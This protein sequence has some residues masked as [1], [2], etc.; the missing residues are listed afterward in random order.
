MKNRILYVMVNFL[1]TLAMVSIMPKKVR[2]KRVNDNERAC[3]ESR[4]YPPV[5]RDSGETEGQR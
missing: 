3:T 1:S 2:V 4:I 5:A